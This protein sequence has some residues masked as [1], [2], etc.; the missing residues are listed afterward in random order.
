MTRRQ[1]VCRHCIFVH[2]LQCCCLRSCKS[3]TT[4]KHGVFL[5]L[6]SCGMVTQT[7]FHC[8]FSTIVLFASQSINIHRCQIAINFQSCC[9]ASQFTQVCVVSPVDWLSVLHPGRQTSEVWRQP[10]RELG[11]WPT[12][13]SKWCQF[14]C[15]TTRRPSL[16]A[17]SG[18]IEQTE[19]QAME[20]ASQP[21]N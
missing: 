7:V 9:H 10:T 1:L 6:T 20:R 5:S 17:M 15:R 8:A 13:H 2:T 21:P 3:T 16:E 4:C 11:L 18:T 19:I 12:R 14:C